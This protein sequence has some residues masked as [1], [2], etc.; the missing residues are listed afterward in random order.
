MKQPQQSFRKNGPKLKNAIDPNI[1]P[2]FG[3]KQ[4]LYYERTHRGWREGW[5]YGFLKRFPL[6]T[7]YFPEGRYLKNSL[8]EISI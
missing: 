4:I 2:I 1:F 7:N 6:K 5:V 8:T 3:W